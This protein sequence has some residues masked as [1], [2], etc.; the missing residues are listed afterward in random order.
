MANGKQ[1]LIFGIIHDLETA[2]CF[3]FSQV[4]VSL[5]FYIY[6]LDYFFFIRNTALATNWKKQNIE[7][8]Q[9][10]VNVLLDFSTILYISSLAVS[11]IYIYI[12]LKKLN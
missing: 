7:I 1:H 6:I 5:D 8:I 11:S 9:V 10:Q 2:V 3:V 4:N 12:G